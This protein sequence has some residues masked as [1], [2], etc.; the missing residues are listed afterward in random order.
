MSC[1]NGNFRHSS[2]NLDQM[3][4]NPADSGVFAGGKSVLTCLCQMHRCNGACG[5]L[6]G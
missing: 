5:L 6:D 4:L 1:Q 3:W 2:H